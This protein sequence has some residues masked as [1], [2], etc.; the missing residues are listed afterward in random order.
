LI[1][2][3]LH[4]LL[5]ARKQTLTLLLSLLLLVAPV[6]ALHAQ[7]TPPTDPTVVTGGDP[8]PIGEPDAMPMVSLLALMTLGMA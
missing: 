7:S 2:Q 8:V 3:T 1:L 6:A 4:T 5:S